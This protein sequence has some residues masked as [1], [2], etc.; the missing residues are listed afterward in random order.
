MGYF[1]LPPTS[2]GD[3]TIEQLVDNV[4][5]NL[6]LFKKHAEEAMKYGDNTELCHY[7]VTTFANYSWKEL[8]RRCSEREAALSKGTSNDQ[9]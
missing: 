1:V 3:C 8:H 5:D 2:M 9:T 6:T 4:I 7:L